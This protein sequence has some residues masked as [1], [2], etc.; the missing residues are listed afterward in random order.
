MTTSKLLDAL[1]LAAALVDPQGTIAEANAAWRRLGLV[2]RVPCPPEGGNVLAALDTLVR[3][4]DRVAREVRAAFGDVLAAIQP[5]SEI[6]YDVGGGISRYRLELCGLEGGCVA[7]HVDVSR[8]CLAIALAE[9][10][11]RQDPLTGLT[12]RRGLGEALER[13][14]QEG[15]ASPAALALIDLDDF[16][17]VNDRFGHAVGDELLR[18]ISQRLA[19]AVRTRDL[20]ARLGGDEFVVLASGVGSADPL[21]GLVER[22]REAVEAPLH[23]VGHTFHIGASIGAVVLDGG[24][25]DAVTAL[26]LADRRMYR[27]KR[28]RAVTTA[29][30]RSA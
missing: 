10:R 14:V 28:Q 2:H 30:E 29:L 25:P 15:G 5:S 4:G 3:V 27:D 18:R 21:T 12:N 19:H 9:Q 6:E 22:L 8:H 24:V 26:A 7:T 20:V 17:F 13:A 11:A 23:I 1:P 16:K